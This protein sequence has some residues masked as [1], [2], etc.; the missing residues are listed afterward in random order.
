MIYTSINNI[1]DERLDI[2]YRI[3]E[4]QL[5]SSDKYKPGVFIGESELV[6][7][8][9]LDEGY[10]PLSFLIIEDQEDKYESIFKRCDPN[11]TVYT[12]KKEIYK[13]LKGYILIKGILACF[14]RKEELT[15]NDVLKDAKRIVV[16]EEVENPTNVGAIFR[17]AAALF[18]DGLLL[19]SE[20]CDPLY[21]RS[22]RVSMGNVFKTKWAYVNRDNYID[23]LHKYG[24]KTVAFTLRNDSVDIDDEILNYEDKLAIIMGS[25][26]YGLSDNTIDKS[27]YAVKIKMNEEVDSLNVASASGIA[28]WQ[29]CKNNKRS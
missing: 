12:V 10:E 11:I 29:L 14:K 22:I 4:K 21:R 13:Q 28:L 20:T 23:D 7:N 15:I 1:N 6:I 19:T 5:K 27:D 2:F 16:L 3:N 25:E 24:F 8:R 9:A 18:A 26:G 17:N